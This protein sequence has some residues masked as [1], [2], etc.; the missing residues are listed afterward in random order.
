LGCDD[1]A[2]IVAAAASASGGDSEAV[3]DGTEGGTKAVGTGDETVDTDAVVTGIAVQASFRSDS[4]WKVR[5]RPSMVNVHGIMSSAS[6]RN[7][8]SS[9]LIILD[10]GRIPFCSVGHSMSAGHRYGRPRTEVPS[11]RP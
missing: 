7:A 11:P 5:R 9:T 2:T 10:N 8:Q 1:A 4:G 6:T 3:Y